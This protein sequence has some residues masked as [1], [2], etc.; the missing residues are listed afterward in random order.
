MEVKGVAFLA[1]QAMAEATYG[2]EPW[3]RFLADFAKREPL[4]QQPVL[5]VTRLPVVAFLALNDALVRTFHGGDTRAYWQFGEA[6]G[7]YALTQGQLRGMF[8]PGEF[9]RFLQFTPFIWKGYFTEGELQVLPGPA[10]TELRIVGVP[11]HHVYFEYAV[12]G[13][14]KG[15]LE[16]L[17]AKA[18]Q[19]QALQGFSRG[20][21]EV[22]YR[23]QVS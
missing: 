15:G 23:F 10:F 13:F 14:A 8:E 2:T 17:G 9:R 21:D 20:D 3:R 16:A 7:R 5:P 11:H 22:R 6:S 4:F 18:L 19:V 1:R 12:M